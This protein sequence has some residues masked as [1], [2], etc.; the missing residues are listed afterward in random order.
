MDAAFGHAKRAFDRLD[1]LDQGN[2]R[3]RAGK[4][5]ATIGA[6]E[7][8]D[9]TGLRQRLEQLGN[10]GRFQPGA[11]GPAA[12]PEPSSIVLMGL[13][14]AGVAALGRRRAARKPADYQF[15]YETPSKV[16]SIPLE[17]EFKDVPLP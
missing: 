3:R 4:A 2:I 5:I 6:A 17:F 16:L 12:V 7:G 15:V 8:L 14:I 13:G 10:G 1:D 9:Q 11:F